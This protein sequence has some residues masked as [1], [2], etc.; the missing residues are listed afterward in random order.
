MNS[1]ECFEC[2]E[3]ISRLRNENEELRSRLQSL[4]NSEF[5]PLYLIKKEVTKP[6]FLDLFAASLIPVVAAVFRRIYLL[7]IRPK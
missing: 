1:S 3:V 4:E 6:A 7:F 2:E 5:T